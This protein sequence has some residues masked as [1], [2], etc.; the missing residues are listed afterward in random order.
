[1]GLAP[2]VVLAG[3]Y[4]VEHI[5]GAGGMGQVWA[6]KS[7]AVGNEVAIKTLAGPAADNAEMVMRFRR[8]ANLLARLKSDHVARVIDFASD[9]THGLFLVM[10]LVHGESLS[11][12][13]AG[14]V[15]PVEEAVDLGVDLLTGM[16]DL[17]DANVVHRDLKPGNVIVGTRGSGRRKAV[18]VDFGLGKVISAPESHDQSGMSGITSPDMAVGTLEYMAPEQILNSRRV[19][20]AADIYALGAMLYRAVAGRHLFPSSH[21]VALAQAKLTQPPP[22]LVTGRTD[23]IATRFEAVVARAIMRRPEERYGSDKEMLDELTAL[24]SQAR[25]ATVASP[26]RRDA[27]GH[28]AGAPVPSP[29]APRGRGRGG[30]LAAIIAVAVVLGAGLG[31][32]AFRLTAPAPAPVPVPRQEEGR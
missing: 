23:P 3:R 5:L 17:H 25:A 14:R 29:T 28:A 11:D 2:G 21:G 8:E 24:Q 22:A 32:A 13:L 4:R 1:M 26:A 6:G 16:I 10:D 12:V 20:G 30:A 18:I 19:T 15:L 9:E 7:I 31:Y 27:Q